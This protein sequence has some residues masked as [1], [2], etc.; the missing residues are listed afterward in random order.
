[1]G[2]LQYLSAA[3]KSTT[4]RPPLKHACPK[5]SMSLPI[6][7]FIRREAAG[8]LGLSLPQTGLA[9]LE[10]SIRFALAP[11][12]RGLTGSA[13]QSRPVLPIGTFSTPWKKLASDFLPH[14][15]PLSTLG[16]NPISTGPWDAPVSLSSHSQH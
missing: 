4:S 9:C 1:M 6:P 10:T 16:I 2:S 7:R 12:C 11:A 15:Q 3:M 5:R 13:G 8:A 14:L